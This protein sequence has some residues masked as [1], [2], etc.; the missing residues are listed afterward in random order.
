MSTVEFCLLDGLVVRDGHEAI[1]LGGPKQR[2]VLAVLLLEAGRPVPA[3]RLIDL[4]WGDDPPRRAESS[5]QAYVS[6]LRRALE[7]DRRPREEPR[8][9]VTRP[10]G[11]ALDVPRA[12]VDVHRFQD[13]AARGHAQ[14]AP[15]TTDA[16][17]NAAVTLDAALALWRGPLL[18]E[19]G[20]EP[21]VT[22]AAERLR[23]VHARAVEDRVDAGLLLGEHAEL[24]GTLAEAVAAEPYR[25]RFR[26]QLAL[27]L[28]RC[29]RQRESLAAIDEARAALAEVGLEPS[30]AVRQLEQDLLD[31]APNLDAPGRPAPGADRTTTPASPAP[32]D[33]GHGSRT[34][35]GREHE[36]AV[37]VD[38]LDASRAGR[39]RAVVVSGEPGIG[40]TRLVEELA[41]RADGAVVAWARC[42]ESAAQ[43]AYWPCIQIGRQLE[44]AG[45]VSP[46][47]VAGLLPDE[48][49]PPDDPMAD[50]MALLAASAKVLTSATRPLVIVVDDLQWADPASLR[51]IEFL[52]GE[53]QRTSTLLVVTVRPIG[54]DGLDASG[55]LID[56]LGELARAPG[57]ARL[58]LA[59]LP[60][61]AV[62]RWLA[63]RS[64]VPDAAV[65]ELVHDRTGG[66]PFFIGEVVE[67]LA[68]EGRL[69]DVQAASRGPAVPAAVH[70][71][72]RRRVGRLAPDSQQLLTAAS[73]IGRTFDV[74]V[75]GAVAGLG[76]VEVLDALDPALESGLVTEHDKPGRFQFAHALVAEALTEE[77][78]AVRRA[79]LHAATVAALVR[80]RGTELDEDV[81]ALAHHAYEGAAAG[82]AEDAYT[83]SV[84]AARLAS[85]RLAHEDA[86]QHWSR[87]ARALEMARP[88]DVRSRHEALLE[89]GLALLR[90]DA[91]AEAY[92]PLVEALELALGTGD[93]DMIATPAAAMNIEGL[94]TAG[95]ISASGTTVG[96]VDVLQRAAAALADHPGAGRALT[97]GALAENGYWQ[98]SVDELDDITL[99]A[100]AEARAQA[101]R[102]VLARTLHKRN[103]AMWR[104]ATLPQRKEAVAEVLDLVG[105]GRPS[106]DLEAMTLFSAA[107]VAW[108]EGDV[109]TALA[110]VRQA[111]G[112]ADRT[113]TPA[114]VTQLAFFDV[115]ILQGLGEV[116]R[117]DALIDAT[118]DLYRRTRRWAA[119]PF[120]AGYKMVG[121][122]EMDRLDLIQEVADALM[123]SAYGPMFGECLAFAFGELGE[124]ERATEITP[125]EPL[126]VDSWA[127]LGVA[128]ATVHNRIG[129][130]DLRGADQAGAMLAPYAGRLAT[131]GT[132]PA[133]GDVHLALGRLAHAHGDDATALAHIDA[134][135]EALARGGL[136]PWHVRALLHRH[137]LTADPADLERA[138][139]ALATR[140]LP[141]LE[142]R[143]SERQA[144][145]K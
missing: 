64:G 73:V 67:L 144:A 71:V 125:P 3:D 36:L 82:I 91:V 54:T 17:A 76:P 126:L 31:Q 21:W 145:S 55:P 97:L 25:E 122:L 10:G 85:S 137:E 20:G 136:V 60:A 53:L 120:R 70:D 41:T 45:V 4:V 78:N 134:S 18:P 121:W 40:K 143:L 7:P 94:W 1:D 110:R 90:V 133:F 88:L 77:L 111:R 96:V 56:C 26:A 14:L 8:V 112:L 50:R 12:A 80:L 34:F 29:G 2:A 103:Q 115:S 92:E 108:E 42:P 74:D 15:S 44:A 46:D 113:G 102:D 47:L 109:A 84:A 49:L 35:V 9:L 129:L 23:E 105:S 93:P 127:F 118:Y 104:A 87:A 117:A 66:N 27:A 72:V 81:A 59:G 39:G 48:A 140:E 65:A 135:V 132:G 98:L 57:A 119:D 28:Y 37:L 58:D 139:S 69:T 22:E 142:R 130:G 114:L 86:A 131:V 138:A 116:E 123:E 141:H 38:A 106:P 32:P 107:S 63:T 100:L 52:A 68:S 19:L 30:R 124:L 75:L 5:L 24:L 13:L 101:D 43:A 6:N 83:W 51:V 89:A 62:E 79:R 11:Y 95:E 61:V 16:A 128:A 33:D 99:E